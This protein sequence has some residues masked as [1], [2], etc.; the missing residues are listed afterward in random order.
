MKNWLWILIL[1]FFFFN[2]LIDG[3]AQTLSW[4]MDLDVP[5]I[6]KPNAQGFQLKTEKRY[7]KQGKNLL[8]LQQSFYDQ[9]GH[10]QYTL[11]HRYDSL[12][13]KTSLHDSVAYQY[14]KTS[15]LEVDLQKRHYIWQQNNWAIMKEE[16]HSCTKDSVFIKVRSPQGEVLQ[17]LKIERERSGL[18]IRG[19]GFVNVKEMDKSLKDKSQL[20][21]DYNH[22]FNYNNLFQVKA[23]S[24]PRRNFIKHHPDTII[25]TKITTKDPAVLVKRPAWIQQGYIGGFNTDFYKVYDKWAHPIKFVVRNYSTFPYYSADVPTVG[26]V[27]CINGSFFKY[28][29][30]GELVYRLDFILGYIHKDIPL[31]RF[32]PPEVKLFIKTIEKPLS[33]QEVEQRFYPLKIV[34]SR[35]P[36]WRSLLIFSDSEKEN[37]DK[38]KQRRKGRPIIILKQYS[39]Y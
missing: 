35:K 32:N 19:T 14:S 23:F 10:L 16:F 24:N 22:Y 21:R 30:S 18:F 38:I 7:L 33:N 9:K 6:V 31:G 3:E 11:N 1:N 15:L 12:T 2:S 5:L 37:P 13:R 36:T 27:D 29:G 34:K 25:R 28:E 17:L 4:Q 26:S 39:F 20:D 8:P